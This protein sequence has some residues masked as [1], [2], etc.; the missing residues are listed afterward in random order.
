MSRKGS[1][2]RSK[3]NWARID[4]LSDNDIDY[5]ESPKLGAEFFKEA[6]WWPGTKKQITIRLDPDILA[7]FRKRSRRY[8]TAINAVL[9]KYVEIQ[10]RRDRR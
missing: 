10:K 1:T 8:Q 5:S 7:Y 4:A 6:I 3:T 2:K 9:R